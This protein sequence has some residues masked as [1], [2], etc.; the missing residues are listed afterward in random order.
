MQIFAGE[1]NRFLPGRRCIRWVAWARSTWSNKKIALIQKGGGLQVKELRFVRVC[2]PST[3]HKGKRGTRLPPWP[4]YIPHDEVIMD[5]WANN[6][7]VVLPPGRYGTQIVALDYAP[8]WS[9]DEIAMLK[10]ALLYQECT[11]ADCRK[12]IPQFNY[13]VRPELVEQGL[14]GTVVNSRR[15]AVG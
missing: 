10:D 13:L 4:E 6:L 1:G 7:E 8:A 14:E 3:K 15:E 5:A 2:E 9:Y 12:R 11:I